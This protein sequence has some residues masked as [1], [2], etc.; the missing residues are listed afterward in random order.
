MRG[1]ES[2]AKAC[3]PE[4]SAPEQ[5]ITSQALSLT[6]EQLNAIAAKV[7]EQLQN[8]HEQPAQQAADPE[9]ADPEPITEEVIDT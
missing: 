7:V 9:Q 4:T 6:E 8:A 1:L 5:P 2:L 3:Q